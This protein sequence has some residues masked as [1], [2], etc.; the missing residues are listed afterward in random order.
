M[1]ERNAFNTWENRPSL[2]EHA[3]DV[4]ANYDRRHSSLL[5]RTDEPL[6][7][8]SGTEKTRDEAWARSSARHLLV[9]FADYQSTC[10]NVK[11]TSM[12]SVVMNEFRT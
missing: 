11:Y 4:L 3:S 1:D 10:D 12:E 8:Q 6:T 9:D 5:A 7:R 2:M